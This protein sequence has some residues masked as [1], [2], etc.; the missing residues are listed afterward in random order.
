MQ[1]L[2]IPLPGAQGGPPDAVI[3]SAVLLSTA[4]SCH[5]AEG[6]SAAQSSRGRQASVLPQN[7]HRYV[8]ALP[9]SAGASRAATCT[10]TRSRLLAAA[11]RAPVGHAWSPAA[12]ERGALLGAQTLHQ[13]HAHQPH[14]HQQHG[15]HSA[16]WEAPGIKRDAR[17][18]ARCHDVHDPQPSNTRSQALEV[19]DDAVYTLQV[20]ARKQIGRTGPW[21]TLD[22]RHAPASAYALCS[23]L[24][25]SIGQQAA[26]SALQAHWALSCLL[27]CRGLSD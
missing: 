16:E 20:A 1:K 21:R 23:F 26:A 15:H 22:D 4:Q 2:R 11:A 24:A 25:T 18:I 8:H 14:P 3:R 9:D 19:L 27:Q 5:A 10:N 6:R 7:L 13:Q 12:A 17:S